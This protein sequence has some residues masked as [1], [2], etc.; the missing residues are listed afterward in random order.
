MGF[1]FVH[2]QQQQYKMSWQ[3]YVSTQL[4]AK[5]LKDAAIVGC[6]GSIWAKSDSLNVTPEEIKALLNN[7]TNLAS[8]GFHLAGKKYFYLSGDDNVVRGKQ[9]KSGVHVVKTNQ[10]VIL[11]LYDDSMQPAEASTVTE[12]LGDY[13]KGVGY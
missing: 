9:G 1:T 7:Y 4:I 11:G 6:D 3:D 2:Q 5:N 13:L 12:T 10:A 8:S